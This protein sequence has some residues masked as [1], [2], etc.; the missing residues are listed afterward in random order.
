MKNFGI[1]DCNKFKIVRK[2]FRVCQ[3]M[4]NKPYSY[5]ERLHNILSI[6]DVNRMNEIFT[7]KNI[8]I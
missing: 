3:R 5:M 2:S 6:R 1:Y 8:C 7:E 4:A